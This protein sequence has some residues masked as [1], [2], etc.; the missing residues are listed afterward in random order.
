MCIN[1]RINDG[2]ALL[3]VKPKIEMIDAEDVAEYGPENLL[4]GAKGI[5]IPPAW[6][7]KGVEGMILATG[8]SGALLSPDEN[9]KVG[10]RIQ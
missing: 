10:E 9:G 1:T 4:R 6:G 8:E 7:S 2:E 3:E 5:I